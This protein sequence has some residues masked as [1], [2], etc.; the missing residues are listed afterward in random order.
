MGQTTGA[1]PIDRNTDLER[2][3][4]VVAVVAKAVLAGAE[5]AA[6]RGGN[7]LEG[8]AEISAERTRRHTQSAIATRIIEILC[9]TE[10][11][12]EFGIHAA[13]DACITWIFIKIHETGLLLAETQFNRI[14]GSV[15][16]LGD[17]DFGHAFRWCTIFVNG[18]S[19]I[20]GTVDKGNQ[21]G[22]L[23]DGS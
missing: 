4:F 22:I 14:N 1:A 17:N 6:Q 18:K 5:C 15:T 12:G 21:V 13:V 9:G 20:F 7:I 8:A 2:R 16:M 3:S 11:G 23:L 10:R 19:V